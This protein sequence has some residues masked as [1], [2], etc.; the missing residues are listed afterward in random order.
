MSNFRINLFTVIGSSLLIGFWRNLKIREG[1]Y[2]FQLQYKWSPRKQDQSEIVLV[3]G[4]YEKAEALTGDG[5]EYILQG[6]KICNELK[7]KPFSAQ[8]YLFLGELYAD[9]DKRE[10]AWENLEKAQ[11]MFQE[12]GMDCWLAKTQ[13][14]LDRL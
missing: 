5:E 1:I 7:I 9:S 6:I 3:Y 12:M 11:K 2:D 13:E 4:G 8:G 14:V 10:K